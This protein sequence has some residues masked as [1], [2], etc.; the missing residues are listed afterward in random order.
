[1][2]TDEKDFLS[3]WSR[4]KQAAREG[5]E[6][7]ETDLEQPAAPAESAAAEPPAEDAPVD[8]SAYAEFD[9]DALDYNSDYTQF[10]EKDV[11]EIVRR[12]AL[13]ALWRSDP[14]L[15]NVDGLNDYDEDFTDAAL[16]VENLASAYKPGKGYRT[17][18]DEVEEAQVAET[19]DA[20]AQEPASGETPALEH[21]E[22]QPLDA[23]ETETANTGP[24]D[25]EPSKT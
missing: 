5:L 16:V 8:E 15:A 19:E 13:R 10:M 12:R 20:P 25:G 11:P 2:T 18:E 3:R 23:E 17:E 14:I 22:D 24:E 21:S 7:P 9:F 1:M 6:Q 4:R